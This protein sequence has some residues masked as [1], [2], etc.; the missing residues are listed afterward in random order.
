MEYPTFITGGDFSIPLRWPFDRVRL[1]EDVTIHEFGHQYWYGMVGSNEFEESWLDEGLNTD[2]EYRAM[3]LAYGP[4]EAELPGGIGFDLLS[5]A[6][7]SYAA[8]SNLDPIRRF[9]WTYASG[10]HYGVNSYRKVG[11]FLAQLKRDLG[12]QTFARAQRAYFQEW[13][14][15]HPS[16][17]DFFDVFQRVSGRDL[18]IYRKNII[19]GTSRLDWRAVVA[20]TRGHEK[21]DGVFDR[22][23]GRLTFEKGRRVK[24]DREKAGER[25]KSGP[26]DTLVVFGNEGE[27]PHDAKARLVFEDGA[28]VDRVLPAEAR[29]VRLKTTYRSKLAWAAVDPDRENAW[30]WNRANDSIVLGTGKGAANTHG[31][32]AALKYFG[33]ASYLVGLFTQLCWALA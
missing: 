7:A 18:S 16:T 13:S 12:A 8:L 3:R 11:L 15:R 6:H 30:E 28:V 2:S 33:W 4:R 20:T 19:D 5:L 32:A 10:N 14:F 21:D 23:E 25:S 27:W 17:T 31:R 9:A 24:P 29:W 26:Y 1:I 22:K